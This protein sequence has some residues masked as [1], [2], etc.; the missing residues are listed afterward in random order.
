MQEYSSSDRQKRNLSTFQ[1]Q[2]PQQQISGNVAPS[3][4]ADIGVN[5]T[6]RAFR[7]HWREVVHRS[8]DANVKTLVLTGVSIP[9]S[10]QSLEFAHAWAS[11]TGRSNLIVTVGVHPHDAKTFSE[12]TID[13]MRQMLLDPLAKAVGECGLDYNRNYSPKHDQLLAFRS[14]VSLA[15]ELAIPMFIHERE[16]HEDLTMVLD[17]FDGGQLPP[18][19]IHCFTGTLNEAQVYIEC[20]YFLSFAGTLCKKERG[21]HLREIIKQIPLERIML[22]TDAPFMGFVKGRKRSEP[23]DVVNVAQQ[24]SETLGIP[25]QDVCGIT[26]QTTKSFFQID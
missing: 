14:Q 24:I 5:L 16:A 9:S 4:V 21:A 17:E 13:D 11:E 15:C 19:V 3:P 25:L 8:V 2:I 23:A 12:R 26:M 1:S 18:I 10:R 7:K 22:E 6:N 20:G